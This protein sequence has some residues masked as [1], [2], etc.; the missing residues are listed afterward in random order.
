MKCSSLY[1]F[2][3]SSWRWKQPDSYCSYTK[4]AVS[5]RSPPPP[6]ACGK[7]ASGGPSEVWLDTPNLQNFWTDRQSYSREGKACGTG[8][9]EADIRQRPQERPS[10]CSE[11]CL[12]SAYRT[13][14]AVTHVALTSNPAPSELKPVSTCVCMCVCV[15]TLKE[16][17]AS[18]TKTSCRSSWTHRR[19]PSSS[20]LHTPHCAGKHTHP[21]TLVSNS[22][23]GTTT[24]LFPGCAHFVCH[25][26]L[27]AE[28]AAKPQK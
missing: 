18:L 2:I 7:P 23:K 15:S 11:T 26:C 21:P 10:R 28:T 20:Q 25:R 19:V 12:L 17:I 22:P 5:I 6:A 27:S 1:L 8:C 16:E 24:T 9:R 3:Y 13:Y 14:C 4:L